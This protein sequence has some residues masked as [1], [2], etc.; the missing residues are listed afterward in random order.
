MFQKPTVALGLLA[1]LVFLV[2]GLT[3]WGQVTP[4]RTDPVIE[5]LDRRIS[6]FLEGVSLGETQSAYQELLAGSQLLKRTKALKALV[7]NTNELQTKY[8]RRRAFERIG[9]RRVGKDLVF[10]RYLYKCENSPV[11]WYFTFYRT[12][13][14]GKPLGENSIWRVITVR[15]DTKLELLGVLPGQKPEVRQP[16]RHPNRRF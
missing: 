14:P 6:Q 4:M 2:D 11:V 16:R 10:L 3:A 15:F 8:G 7:D 13:A 5:A 9:A 1:G 12:P